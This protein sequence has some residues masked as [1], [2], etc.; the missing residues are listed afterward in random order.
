M[1]LYCLKCH[2]HVHVSIFFRLYA[3]PV[4]LTLLRLVFLAADWPGLPSQ[5]NISLTIL[6]SGYNWALTY[7]KEIPSTSPAAIQSQVYPKLC[8][9]AQLQ[10]ASKCEDRHGPV[11]SPVTGV[12]PS[13]IKRKVKGRPGSSQYVQVK[14]I[15]QRLTETIAAMQPIDKSSIL[16]IDQLKIAQIAVATAHTLLT[17]ACQEQPSSDKT[18]TCG[19]QP[20]MIGRAEIFHQ[21]RAKLG[22]VP[23]LVQP[24]EWRPNA[25]N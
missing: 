9:S 1:R 11:N 3:T 16:A 22:E 15:H 25:G 17:A 13:I 24:H 10:M 23:D 2:H 8:W 12:I 21:W 19:Q 6:K 18:D 20:T 14:P 4:F 7:L 5:H